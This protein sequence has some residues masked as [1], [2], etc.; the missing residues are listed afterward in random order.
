MATGPIARRDEV[1]AFDRYCIEELHVPAIVLMENAGRQIADVARQMLGRMRHRQALVLAGGGNNGG[2]GYVVAR[3]LAID[4][5][6]TEVVLLAPRSA[7][8]GDADTNLKIL[9]AMGLEI[10][11]IE[12]GPEDVA[13]GLERHLERASLIIDGLLGTGTQGEIREPYSTAITTINA[14]GIPTLAID[15]PSGL[16]CDTG[17]PLGPTIRAAKTVTMAALKVGFQ[18]PEAAAYTGEIILA[19]IGV[20]WRSVG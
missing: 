13:A 20:P 10:H 9:E 3:H 14:A 15:I 5:I 7:V 6:S 2:D 16:D 11:V 17:Q 12:G 19:D 8:Q 4:N 1:R 18:N